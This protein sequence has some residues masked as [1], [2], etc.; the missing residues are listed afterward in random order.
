[1]RIA[2]DHDTSKADLRWD[3]GTIPLADN[4]VDCEI[5]TEVFEHCFELESVM[6]EVNQRS[7]AAETLFFTVPFLWPL[8]EVP[9]DACR[10]TPFALERSLTNPG[11]KDVDLKALGGW[12]ASLAQMIGLWARRRPRG[13]FKRGV[14]S[15]LALPLIGYLN[16]KDVT[17]THIS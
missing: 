3:G 17:S 15:I 4:S 9:H 6:R 10:Y 8:H 12:D 11:L 14:I 16:G 1:L 2:F 13:K 5:A 7:E